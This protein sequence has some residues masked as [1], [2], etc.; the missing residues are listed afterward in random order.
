MKNFAMTEDLVTRNEEAWKKVGFRANLSANRVVYSV[1]FWK[2]MWKVQLRMLECEM[3]EMNV[4]HSFLWFAQ[5]K[6]PELI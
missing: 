1:T 5:G 4:S 3:I 6:A 2:W